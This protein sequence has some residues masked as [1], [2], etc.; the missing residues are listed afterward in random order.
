[1][2]NRGGLRISFSEW[3]DARMSCFILCNQFVSHRLWYEFTCHSLYSP[4]Y[5]YSIAEN[6]RNVEIANIDS[7][8]YMEFRRVFRNYEYSRQKW[9]F[10]IPNRKMSKTWWGSV[11]FKDSEFTVKFQYDTE[12]VDAIKA[13]IPAHVRSWSAADKCWKIKDH[14][15]SYLEPIV[16][17]WAF[18][19]APEAAKIFK[20]GSNVTT[21]SLS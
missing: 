6:R 5:E 4:F 15:A 10:Q 19:I 8:H 1:M 11:F 3:F 2:S 18:K 16:D 21:F 14:G 20:A 12:V 17:R 13:E 7:C 9:N